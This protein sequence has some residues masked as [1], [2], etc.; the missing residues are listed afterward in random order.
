MADFKDEFS[1]ALVDHLGAEIGR[2]WPG[3]PREEWR[4]RA[5]DG[6]DELR[7]L[8]RVAHLSRVLGDLLPPSFPDAAAVLHEALRSETLD[9]WMTLPCGWMV[10]DR[11]IDEPEVALPLLAALSPRFS[12]EGTVRPFI[13]RHPEIT[14]GY[15]REWASDPDHEVRRLV[16]ECTRPRLPWAPQLPTHIADPQLG[17]VFLDM[18]FDDPSEYVR[19]S[20]ANHLNDISKDHRE[21][22]LECARRWGA[23]STRGEFVVRHGLRTLV[24][25]GDPEAL[26]LLGYAHGNLV[27]LDAIDCAPAVVAIGEQVTLTAVLSVDE[28]TRAAIDYVVHY[29][30]ATGLKAGKVFKLTS[31][32]LRPGHPETI[33]RRHRFRHVSIRT[34]R[35]GRHRIEIQVNGRVLG[36]CDIEVVEG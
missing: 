29:Q 26:G 31:R 2:A 32:D 23:A 7:L 24:K 33:V 8:E 6:L 18:L 16:S 35:P 19:R 14:Y 20:V 36:G 4:T 5:L 10:A 22:A 27:T 1:P 12:S 34:I 3:F 15:L 21:V 25:R 11:G 13:R 28:P 17:I 9:G 30:G